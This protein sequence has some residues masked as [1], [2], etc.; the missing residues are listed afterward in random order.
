V[1]LWVFTFLIARSLLA[2]ERFA[3]FCF[4]D[5]GQTLSR[6]T[7]VRT[8]SLVVLASVPAVAAGPLGAYRGS[9]A[10]SVIEICVAVSSLG[11]IVLLSRVAELMRW[12]RDLLEPVV[13]SI[14]EDR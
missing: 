13:P 6:W 8:A 7:L 12:N 14:E 5:A 1:L 3:C 4:G 9:G 11:T 10:D 2:G